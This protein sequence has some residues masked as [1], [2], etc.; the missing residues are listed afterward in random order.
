[1]SIQLLNGLILLNSGSV[2][3]DSDCCCDD[4]CIECN[5]CPTCWNS[6]SDPCA[7]LDSV[8]ITIAGAINGTRSDCSCSSINATYTLDI[9]NNL[10]NFF[11]WGPITGCVVQVPRLSP[12]YRV[13]YDVTVRAGW[14]FTTIDQTINNQT[15]LDAAIIPFKTLP[16]FCNAMTLYAGHHVRVIVTQ[17]VIFL[18]PL[19][20]HSFEQHYFFSFNNEDIKPGCPD[21][22][23][24]G[25]CSGLSSGGTATHLFSMQ[26][27][28]GP[29]TPSACFYDFGFPEL[30]DLDSISVTIG[31]PVITTTPPPP[32][33]P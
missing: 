4:P 28:F 22:Q 27:G 9:G 19:S 3:T 10:C 15:D 32:P 23:S 1:M 14:Q 25:L 16:K 26:S 30:C 6:L 21:D 13:V 31:T 7:E 29:V 12:I 8:D 2:A 5:P 11:G 24:Y 17:R 20:V 33:P 18:V